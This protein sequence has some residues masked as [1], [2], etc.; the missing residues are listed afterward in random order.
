M[1]GIFFEKL[2]KRDVTGAGVGIDDVVALQLF[3]LM[4]TVRKNIR[5]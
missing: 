1:L 3:Y 2:L 4:K 5:S